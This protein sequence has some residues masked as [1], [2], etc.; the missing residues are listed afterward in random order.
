MGVSGQPPALFITIERA[1][2]KHSQAAMAMLSREIVAHARRKYATEIEGVYWRIDVDFEAQD[3]LAEAV[4]GPTTLGYLVEETSALHHR[5]DARF[6]ELDEMME[7]IDTPFTKGDPAQAD[8]LARQVRNTID[9]RRHE[10]CGTDALHPMQSTT[11]PPKE[12][13]P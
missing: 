9:Q 12:V 2:L 6:S 8:A 5:A 10:R 7:A 3:D 11:T 4:L 13:T 1:A